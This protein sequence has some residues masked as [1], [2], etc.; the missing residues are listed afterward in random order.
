MQRIF[1]LNGKRVLFGLFCL[2]AAAAAGRWAL[3]GRDGAV[4][5]EALRT[6]V[7][8]CLEDI[9]AKYAPD[10]RTAVFQIAWDVHGST[11]EVHGKV[12][13]ETVHEALT[14]N[15][16][17]VPGV[18]QVRNRVA[19]LPLLPDKDKTAGIVTT[20]VTNLYRDPDAAG[21]MVTQ[22]V[23]GDV[24][25]LLD[26]EGGLYL[27]RMDN[28][29]LGWVLAGDVRVV[30]EAEK[31]EYLRHLNRSVVSTLAPMYQSPDVNSPVVINA[32]APARLTAGNGTGDWLP[33]SLPD[34]KRV[35]VLKRH[36]QETVPLRPAAAE[37]MIP[38]DR[39]EIVA[40]AV[41]FAGIPYFWGG[42]TPLGIDCSGFTQMIYRL[43]G[44]VLPRDADQQFTAG[45]AVEKNALQAGDLVFFAAAGS[46][47]GKV[48]PTHVGIY[49]GGDEYIHASTGEG[50]V[51]VS[52]LSRND[53]ACNP[54]AKTIL[55]GARRILSGT[56][57]LH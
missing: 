32:V 29:Y 56:E 7:E 40:A 52:P 49:L 18:R 19:K 31:E 46:S 5:E 1:T 35:W 41:R 21:E 13:E 44:I 9:R 57:N 45:A 23:L 8:N 36:V 34:G 2:L 51:A 20:T 14:A 27:V 50:A 37:E 3:M 47:G 4:P 42:T 38:G 15:L 33:V 10:P 17:T 16:R 26:K 54:G 22:A 28:N 24:L 53:P 39:G 30:S 55:I 48:K 12:T 11:V 6:A 43:C 25:T